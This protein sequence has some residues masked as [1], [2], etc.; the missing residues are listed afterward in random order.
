MT[1]FI[2]TA[3]RELFGT[4]SAGEQVIV[5]FDIIDSTSISRSAIRDVVTSKG[6]V[7][8]TLYHRAEK[9]YQITFA[10]VNGTQRKRLIEML[11]STESGES[12]QMYIYG[13]ESLPITVER[14]DN[15][16]SFSPYMM[17]GTEDLD[18]YQT[19]ITVIQ[20]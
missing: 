6:G 8:E 7:R 10:P 18:Y 14:D 5:D 4:H 19:S 2:Y 20:R 3:K 11:A 9:R 13:N 15:E 1:Q 16:Y 12:F 17:V